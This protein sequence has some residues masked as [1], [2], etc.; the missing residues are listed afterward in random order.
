MYYH[1]EYDDLIVWIDC[2]KTLK[3]KTV[4]L[5]QEVAGC[6]MQIVEKTASF[7]IAE[8][9]APQSC[10]LSF[11]VNGSSGYAILRFSCQK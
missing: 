10:Q 6:H 3:N 1:H 9:A 2:H 7:V 5:P 8:N 4:S 11:D